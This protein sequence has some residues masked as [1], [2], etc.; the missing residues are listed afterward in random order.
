LIEGLYANERLRVNGTKCIIG[1]WKEGFKVRDKH[2]FKLILSEFIDSDEKIAY[3]ITPM[4]IKR[5][6]INY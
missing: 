1:G 6:L 2:D 3:S 4:P 5:E